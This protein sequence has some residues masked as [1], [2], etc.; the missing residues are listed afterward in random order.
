MVPIFAGLIIRELFSFWT[1]HPTDFELWV[2]LGY[3]MNHGGDPYGVLS[4]VPGLSFADVFGNLNEPTVAYLPFWP[5]LTGIIYALYSL[6]GANNRF[7]YYF[8]LKQP[9]IFGDIG[10]AY[11][12]FS[13]VH[14]RKPDLTSF[15]TLF[16]WL[17]SPFT[18]ILSGIWGMFDAIAICFVIASAMSHHQV[19]KSL[20]IG[21]GIFVKSIPVIYAAPITVKRLKSMLGLIGAL[22]LPTLLS[23]VTFVIM[24]WPI[25]IVS[26]TLASTAG[27]GGSSMSVWDVFFYLNNLGLI[28]D[29]TPLEY[30]T[31]GILWIPALIVFTWIAVKRFRTETDYGLIQALI[32]CTLI[33]LIFKSR[34]TE[35]YALYL[36]ALAAIDVALWNPKRKALL[37]GTMSVVMVYLVVNNYFL[38]RFLSPVYPGFANFENYLYGMIGSTRNAINFLSGTAFTCLNIKYLVDVL[39]TG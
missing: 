15:S 28:R 31:L 39:R 20:Y 16:F 2:R 1:G 23:L 33:F 9:A 21:L 6:I 25:S 18:I 4:S 11:L 37:L 22:G 14:S 10:L 19:K 17:F 3:A 27:K 30:R 26:L 32:V 24:K 36:F 29:L 35:Q 5:L 7:L 8:L 13:Y 12:L 34:V 38:V